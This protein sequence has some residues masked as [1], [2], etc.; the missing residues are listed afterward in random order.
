LDT[1]TSSSTSGIRH[2][3]PDQSFSPQQESSKKCPIVPVN[4][5]V[6]KEVLLTFVL[7]ISSIPSSWNSKLFSQLPSS[8]FILLHFDFAFETHPP[9][10]ICK[11][12]CHI[13]FSDDHS[14]PN[15][16]FLDSGGLC[17]VLLFVLSSIV[18]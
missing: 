13:D 7:V 5:Y 11:L 17:L 2:A 8:V 10:S 4:N 6:A 9:T 1:H 3:I 18:S 12:P 14:F 16:S 15:H